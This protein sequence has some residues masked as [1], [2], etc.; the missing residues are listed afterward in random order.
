[1]T[2]TDAAA[3]SVPWTKVVPL[4]VLLA[5]ADCFWVVTLRGAVGAIERADPPFAAWVR[6]TTLLLPL[7]VLAVVVALAAAHRWFGPTPRGAR[8]VLLT[9]GLVWLAGTVAGVAFLVASTTYDY[10]LEVAGLVHMSALHGTCPAECLAAGLEATGRQQLSGGGARCRPDRGDQRARGRLPRVPVGWAG[11]DRHDATT[12]PTPPADLRLLLACG[13][14]GAAVIHAAVVPEHWEEWPLAG[15]F[16]VVLAVA[17]AGCAVAVARSQSRAALVAALVVSAGPLL[18]WAVSRT[19]GLPV[20]PEAGTPEGVGMADAGA[21]LLELVTLVLAAQLLAVPGRRRPLTRHLRAG[22]VAGVLALTTIGVGGS[23]LSSVH[24]F[25]GPGHEA[26]EA[27]SADHEVGG[28]R[29]LT[30]RPSRA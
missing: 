10:R 17:E 1:M 6:E 18:L 21:S 5:A 27:G 28:R 26:H 12:G 30:A 9:L 16:F 20:G 3:A 25:G 8:P 19:T 4:A 29:A 2:G 22:A 23:G 15:A 13:L 7:F 24:A 11:G 14:V